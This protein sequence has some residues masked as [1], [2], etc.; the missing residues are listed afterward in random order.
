RRPAP[1][2]GGPGLVHRRHRRR[3]GAGTPGGFPAHGPAVLPLLM[4][5]E[6]T[7]LL[8]A[9][10]RMP[11]G[12]HAHS[13]GLE[14]AAASG[15]VGDADQLAS[16][17]RGRLATVGLVDAALAAAARLLDDGHAGVVGDGVVGDGVV[18]DGVG[19]DGDGHA[20]RNGP[21][22]WPGLDAEAAARCPGP[23][24]RE[25]GRGQGRRMLRLARSAWPAIHLDHLAEATGGSPM[26]PV[27]LGATATAAGV[28]ALRE[29]ATAAG[30]AV[31]GPAWAAVRAMALDPYVVARLLADLAPS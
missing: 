9:D 28:D 1:H 30:A 3:R 8:F 23:A 6:A 24:L 10:P 15:R 13:G 29:A 31:T 5:G 14:E 20:A 27:A 25:V 18:G 2:R 19:S 22:G 21:G 4:T 7:F 12:G 16:F 11:T 17:L 26:W